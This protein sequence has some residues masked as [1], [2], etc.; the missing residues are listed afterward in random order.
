MRLLVRCFTY[1]EGEI[2]YLLCM[3]YFP[4]LTV[5]YHL[6][7]VIISSWIVLLII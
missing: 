1:L 4:L 2:V 7:Y 6:N 3:S 5:S